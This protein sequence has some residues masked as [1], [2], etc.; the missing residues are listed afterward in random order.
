MINSPKIL[1]NYMILV[2]ILKNKRETSYL[3]YK[4]SKVITYKIAI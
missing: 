3:I 1:F 2:H 4:S